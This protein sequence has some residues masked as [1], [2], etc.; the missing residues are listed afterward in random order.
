MVHLTLLHLFPA[1]R[2]GAYVPIVSKRLREKDKMVSSPRIIGGR[3]APGRCEHCGTLADAACGCGVGYMPVKA[4]V[5][6]AKAIAADPQASNRAIAEKIGVTRPYFPLGQ[7]P[8][9]MHLGFGPFLSGPF[10]TASSQLNAEPFA[11]VLNRIYRSS[12]NRGSFLQRG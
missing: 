4:S 11:L 8:Q 12:K 6:A 9:L 2:A 10:S 7:H 1:L 3:S 5:A